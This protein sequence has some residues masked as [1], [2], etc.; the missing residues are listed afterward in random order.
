MNSVYDK[1]SSFF[2]IAIAIVCLLAIA[3]TLLPVLNIAATSLSGRH[4]IAKGTVGI[5]PE[6]FTLEAY[7]RVFTDGR[8]SHSL[9]YSV[10]LTLGTGLLSTLLTI[11]AAYPLSKTRLRGNRF[12]MLVV[13]VTMYVSAGT[14][15]NYLL[16]R[17][18]NLMNT[19]WALV[20]PALIS[21]FNLIVLRTFFMGISPS[22]F[23]AAY[24]D[25]SGE[26]SSLFRI[27]IPLSM[28]SIATIMLFYSVARWNGITDVLYYIKDPDL[29]TLQYQLNLLLDSVT[30]EYP[31]EEMATMTL[32]PENV[33]SAAIIFTMVPIL[34]V[35]PFVQKYFT[36]GFTIGG[37]KE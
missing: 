35:Y 23:E 9:I 25:G 33:K 37:L 27:A 17:D 4:A 10:L 34:L 13:V 22:L 5:F 30:I 16:I 31:P 11:L 7:E 1:K 3:I 29:Y 12:F 8:F 6:D 32:A 26:W 24:M 20:L 19:V 28:P 21:P 36:M 15:P 2:Q 18:L 14:V